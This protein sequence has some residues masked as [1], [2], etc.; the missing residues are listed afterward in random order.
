MELT[1]EYLNKFRRERLK[2]QPRNERNEQIDLFVARLNA[3]RI[4]DGYPKLTYARVAK[5]LERIP[6]SDLHAIYRKCETYRSFGAGLNY[7]LKPRV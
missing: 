7:E 2:N 6:T 4:T 5:M 1:S 3:S